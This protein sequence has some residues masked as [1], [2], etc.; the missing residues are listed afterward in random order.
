[1]VPV[2]ILLACSAPMARAHQPYQSSAEVRLEGEGIELTVIASREIAVQLA[3]KQ[4]ASEDP[5]QRLLKVASGLYEVSNEGVKMTPERVF[6]ED[7]EGE[8]VFSAIYPPARP[9]EL[10][11]R[12]VY[13]DELPIGYGGSLKVMDGEGR[14]LGFQQRLRR[15]GPFQTVSVRIAPPASRPELQPP[16]VAAMRQTSAAIAPAVCGPRSLCLAGVAA[17]AWMAGA[18]WS[19]TRSKPK[20]EIHV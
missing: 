11:L 16:P 20:E 10:K 3:D 5:R 7:R 12:A 14:I 4:D 15:G 6:F 1:M 18:A 9:G 17:V 13:L 2:G 8:S 19:R